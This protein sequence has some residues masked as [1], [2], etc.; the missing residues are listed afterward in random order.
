MK[1]NHLDS[2]VP[3]GRR[4]F[5]RN[6]LFGAFSASLSSAKLISQQEKQ[7]ARLK[8]GEMF[9]R[10][11]GRTDLLIS[12]ISLGGSPLPAKPILYQAIERG[13]NYIDTSHSYMNGNS[14][15][16]IGQLLKDMGRDKIHV[17]TKFHLRGKWSEE[18]IISSVEGS[19]RRLDTDYLDVLLIHGASDEKHLTD[20]RV[21]GAF[22]KFK[23]QGKYRFRGLS[24][25]S[26]HHKVVKE[27]VECGLYDMVQLGYN[28][29]DIRN[30]KKEIETYDDYLGQSGIRRLLALAK[31]NDVG[32]IAQKTLKVGGK[33][34][35]LEK[36]RT[37]TTSIFQAM[38]K[39]V[40]ENK[41]LTSA[42][43]E[44]LTY[45]QLEE[46]LAVAGKVLSEKER[47]N[48]FHF[49]VENSE[50]YCHMCGL[51]EINCPS[52]VKTTS[53]LR[54]LAYYEDYK[55]TNLAKQAYSRLKPSEGPH[56]CQNCGDCE[57]LCPY[58]VSIR[59]R[60]KE[61]HS[62]LRT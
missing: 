14:E 50:N 20:E 2:N 31:S 38:L 57:R 21:L 22:E 46:D 18:S 5:M 34:Q 39:W 54:Y 53:I 55:K 6:L 12:E 62:I 48:L 30:T 27:A 51:C 13:V 1:N 26:N 59:E 40:L 43:T 29:F 9:Y 16:Q 4:S 11:L 35:N 24:C 44:M 60:L 42:L 36:Y 19:L 25:H 23:K 61:A 3:S 7:G 45:E 17:G 28:V 47:V 52:H 58:G 49:V 37:G 10:R 8:K 32:I 15:R 41:N 33:R 56:S